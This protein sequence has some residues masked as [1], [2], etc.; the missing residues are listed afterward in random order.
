MSNTCK[1]SNLG[2]ISADGDF[3]LP[4]IFISYSHQDTALVA[5]ILQMMQEN[6]FRFWYDE[7]IESGSQWDDVLYERITG[8]TQFVCFFTHNAVLSEHV[9]NEVHLAKKYGK[10]ILPV[11]L[12]DVTLRGGL[13]LALDRK[14]SLTMSDYEPEEFQRQLCRSLDRQTLKKISTS[15]DSIF[16]QLQRRYQLISQIGNG[17]SGNVFLAKNIHTGGNVVI[18]QAS[19]D[20]SYIGDSIRRSYRN[21]CRALC[22][23]ASCHAPIAIDFLSDEHNFALVET[24]VPGTQLNKLEGL[25]DEQIVDIFCKT[26][27]VLQAFHDAGI[28]H[29]DIK[30][31]HIFVHEDQVF[32]VDFGG[33]HIAG[34]CSDNHT[35]GTIHY[36]APEQFDF[37]LDGR[38]PCNID[39]RTDI[40][41]LGKSLLFTLAANHGILEDR[42]VDRDVTVL[43][44]RDNTF[45]AKDQVYT[46]DQDRYCDEIHPLLRAVVDKM[47]DKEQANRF[48]SMTEVERC[49]SAYLQVD[50]NK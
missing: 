18:K 35:I 5:E 47:T 22:M 1:I 8:C 9:K 45:Y 37:S 27:R 15:N 13:E 43:L 21:E 26:A 32:L 41:A 7:G 42:D 23:Q 39:G 24:F 46:L 49:L 48:R 29:C 25:S 3:S 44:D 28:V 38:E 6:H 16:E 50:V 10:Q 40:F 34:Q 12:D 2:K 31:E 33:C 14:Q 36:A 30:P 17:F 4:Y 19:A 20:D 11:F